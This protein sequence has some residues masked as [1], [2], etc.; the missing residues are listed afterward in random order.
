MRCRCRVALPSL[1]NQKT[2]KLNVYRLKLVQVPLRDRHV[3]AIS[4]ETLVML[5]IA[6]VKRHRH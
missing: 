1:V 5:Q 2:D 6:S 4:C 3:Y